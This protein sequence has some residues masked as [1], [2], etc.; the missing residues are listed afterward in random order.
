ME[1]KAFITETLLQI[2]E[3]VLNAQELLESKGVLI[4]PQGFFWYYYRVNSQAFD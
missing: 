3:G 1:L 4:N 2:S